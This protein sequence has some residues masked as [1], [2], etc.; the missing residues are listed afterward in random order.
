MTT[1][2]IQKLGGGGNRFNQSDY[3]IGRYAARVPVG[4]TLEDILH[5]E[6]WQNH[7]SSLRPGMEI[8]VLGDDLALDCDLR[9]LT[10]TKTTAKMRLLRMF[11]DAGTPK[12]RPAEISGVE[13]K[14]AGPNHKWRFAHA[15]EVIEHGFAT[16]EEA[17]EAA[18]KYM[19]KIAQ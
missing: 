12:V 13:L 10:V 9:V 4:T 8:N 1:T 16:E 7:L 6:F 3:L 5:P 18:A 15:G 19:A 17:A 14:W 2:K 11:D